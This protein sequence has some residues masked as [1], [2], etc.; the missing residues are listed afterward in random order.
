[1]PAVSL[2]LGKVEEFGG[3]PVTTMAVK[4][5]HSTILPPLVLIVGSSGVKAS[6]VYVN[7]CSS[8]LE[9][10][11]NK[12]K[13]IERAVV[14]KKMQFYVA[15]L[16]HPKQNRFKHII[17]NSKMMSKAFLS[18]SVCKRLMCTMH[19]YSINDLHKLTTNHQMQNIILL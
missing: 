19:F 13:Y 2:C 10:I 11:C 9:E 1:M 16:V 3:S 7:M 8:G 5:A 12:F 6:G 15:L 4:Q 18:V 14:S 17:K